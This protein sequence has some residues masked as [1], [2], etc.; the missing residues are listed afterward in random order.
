MNGVKFL[1][2]TNVVIG[3]LSGQEE[4]RALIEEGRVS[5]D[6]SAISQITRIELLSFAELTAEAEAKIRQFLSALSIL[7]LD[8]DVESAAIALRRNLRMKLPDAII[9]ATTQVHGLTLLTLDERL[10]RAAERSAS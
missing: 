5:L 1:L 6:S 10:R 8:E 4:T 7:Y 2:D 9:L 3:V